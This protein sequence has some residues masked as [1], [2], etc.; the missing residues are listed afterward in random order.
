M[1]PVSSDGELTMRFNIVLVE[2]VRF[3]HAVAV[4][5]D[6]ARLLAASLDSL[7]H[8]GTAQVNVVEPKAMNII[9]G[10]HAAHAPVGVP[11][12][13]YQL[14]QLSEGNERLQPHWLEVLRQAPQ[15]WDY[16]PQNI[17]YLKSQGVHTVRF[18]P[19]GFHPA[20]RTI[21]RRKKDID[22]LHYGSLSDRRQRILDELSR[23]CRLQHVFAVYGAA[24]DELIARAKIV[25]NIH[26]YESAIFEQVRVSYLLNNG[27]CVVTEQSPGNLYEGMVASAPYDRLVDRCLALLADDAERERIA[28]EG[29]R[30]FESISMTQIVRAAIGDVVGPE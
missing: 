3:K 17:A 22:V 16:D 6:L 2:H 20:L 23:R 14:E 10:Y 21:P 8:P 4:F 9:L 30:R 12:I 7:G 1:R 26:L 15:I 5:H 28:A 11:W 25:L 27:C 13:P 29:A 18:V 24:R 19:I